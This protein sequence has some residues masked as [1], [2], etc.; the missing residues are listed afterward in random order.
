MCIA[1]LRVSSNGAILYPYSRNLII[2]MKTITNT[3]VSHVALLALFGVTALVF[4]QEES[5]TLTTETELSTETTSVETRPTGDPEQRE[6]AQAEREARQEN[7]QEQREDVQANRQTSLE[8]RGEQVEAR[9]AEMDVKTE[10]RQTQVAEK[11]A[12]LQAKGQERIT[13]LASNLSNRIDAVIVRIQNII[14]RI[15]SR[16][17]KFSEQGVDTTEAEENL[18]AAQNSVDRAKAAVANIDAEVAAAVGSED[19]RAAWPEVKATI[20]T[21]KEHLQDARRALRACVTS[22]KEA[23]LE[24]QTVNGADV[25]FPANGDTTED[26][27]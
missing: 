15:D 8:E 21:V 19:V 6:T 7:Q 11:R 23:V 26:S 20:A 27:E 2:F 10:E 25:V 4:A 3:I 17:D 24:N 22:L 1:P 14:D 5:D 16:I 18:A 9:K 13:N 12:A